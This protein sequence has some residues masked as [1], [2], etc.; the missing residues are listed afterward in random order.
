MKLLIGVAVL[1]L[2]LWIMEDYKK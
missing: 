1:L 2:A